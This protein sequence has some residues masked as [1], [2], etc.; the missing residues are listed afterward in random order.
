[1][2][3]LKVD[4]SGKNTLLVMLYVSLSVASRAHNALPFG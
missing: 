3:K 1:M 4:I 2:S